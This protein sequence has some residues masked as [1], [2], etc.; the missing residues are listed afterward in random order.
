MLPN[1]DS[2]LKPKGVVWEYNLKTTKLWTNG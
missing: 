1:Y 2:R